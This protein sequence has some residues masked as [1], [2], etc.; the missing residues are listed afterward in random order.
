MTLTDPVM[1]AEPWDVEK[2][3]VEKGLT[4]ISSKRVSSKR[5]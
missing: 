5:V 4:L 3:L 2:G 1:L